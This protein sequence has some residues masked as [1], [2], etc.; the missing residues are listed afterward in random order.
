MLLNAIG[1]KVLSLGPWVLFRGVLVAVVVL[2]LGASLL[3]AVVIS[4]ME[5]TRKARAILKGAITA[6]AKALIEAWELRA[7]RAENEVKELRAWQARAVGLLQ[8]GR[9]HDR[10]RNADASSLIAE[11]GGRG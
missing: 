6:E 4:L 9:N 1:M 8:E 11:A 3:P 2:G 5:R 10:N 7:R